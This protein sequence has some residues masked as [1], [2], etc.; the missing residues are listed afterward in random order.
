LSEGIQQHFLEY[1][2]ACASLSLS[3]MDEENRSQKL[4]ELAYKMIEKSNDI[5]YQYECQLLAM[6]YF[7]QHNLRNCLEYAM[8]E[9]GWQVQAVTGSK[10]STKE[11]DEIK[12]TIRTERA[13]K[14]LVAAP[15]STTEVQEI[16]R[17]GIPKEEDKPKLARHKLLERIPGIEE[18]TITQKKI[19]RVPAPDPTTEKTLQNLAGAEAESP[20]P[21]DLDPVHTCPD[22]SINSQGNCGQPE[23]VGSAS[24]GSEASGTDGFIEVE[25]EVTRAVFDADFIKLV[26]FQDRGLIS[27]LEGQVLLRNPQTA[28]FL[29][30]GKWQKKLGLF[31]DDTQVDGV[32]RINLTTYKSPWLKIHTLLEMGIGYFLQPEST[33]TQHTPEAIAFWERGKDPKIA[34]Q[35]GLEVGQNDVCQYIGRVLDSYGLKRESEKIKL[36]TGERVR[37]YR[38]KPLDPICQAI[39]ECVEAKVLVSMAEEEPVLDGEKLIEKSPSVGAESPSPQALD[40]VHTCPNNSINSQGD[41]GQAEGVGSELEQL[42]EA[43][44]FVETADDFAAVVEGSPRQAIEDAIAL[45]DSA[46]RRLQLSQW[47]TALPNPESLDEAIAAR[48][49]LDF[50]QEGDPVW[51]HHPMAKEG[52]VRG[53]VDWIR[54]GIL[55]VQSDVFGNLIESPDAIAPGDWVLRT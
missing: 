6:A 48:P 23:G 17:Q 15:L 54:D 4:I 43:L 18:K 27:R 30:Q 41:Y 1:T 34:R 7:E 5:H 55:R 44:P 20:S 42:L 31:Q 9:A 50:Y 24:D 8:R 52:W 16:E 39:Y 38:P 53:V 51:F 3:D 12:A 47:L 36:P 35:I 49:S 25:Q 11:L 29:Q 33:W 45:Q 13:E 22:N 10:I 2:R 21:Q 46:P 19:I 37:Q 32:K 26:K 28:K 40:P 14:I